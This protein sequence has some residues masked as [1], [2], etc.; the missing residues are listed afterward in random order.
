MDR[1]RRRAGA[2]E[3]KE[4]NGVE[5]EDGSGT[6]LV[7]HASGVGVSTR[8]TSSVMVSG[9]VFHAEMPAVEVVVSLFFFN[10][11]GCSVCGSETSVT[12]SSCSSCP[13]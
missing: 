4:D 9:G 12:K 6:P 13:T 8:R 1:R 11:Q 10:L 3:L 5:N 2:S 7:P